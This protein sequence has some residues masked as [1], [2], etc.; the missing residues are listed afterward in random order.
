MPSWTSGIAHGASASSPG[1]RRLLGPSELEQFSVDSS[2]GALEVST[3]GTGTDLAA[4]RLDANADEGRARTLPAGPM[5][6]SKK[7]S[8][9]KSSTDDVA[10]GLTQWTACTCAGWCACRSRR[11]DA[12]DACT[13]S[14]AAQAAPAGES[15]RDG[16]HMCMFG[17]ASHSKLKSG[18]TAPRP[19]SFFSSMACFSQLRRG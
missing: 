13:R 12:E 14:L 11:Y 10:S 1:A 7:S 18:P 16:S 9:S 19:P 17:R 5:H 4:A 6:I 2:S 3:S 8:S 15:W